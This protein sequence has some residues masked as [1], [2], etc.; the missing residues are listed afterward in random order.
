MPRPSRQSLDEDSSRDVGWLHAL[1]QVPT[2]K[3]ADGDGEPEGEQ[4]VLD[5]SAQTA[6]RRFRR[7]KPRRRKR[8]GTLTLEQVLA[9]SDAFRARHGRWPSRRAGAIAEAPGE[10]WGGVDKALRYGRRGF[11]GGSSLSRLMYQCRGVAR[12]YRR[13]LVVSEQEIVAWADAYHEQHGAWPNSGAG[14]I[15]GASVPTWA[16]VDAALRVGLHGLK[17]G[18]LLAKLLDRHR[19]KPARR[20][21]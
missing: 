16:A 10:T 9:W 6:P 18:S 5:H 20:P 19:R 7:S 14:P 3:I 12:E 1:K 11:R 2:G 21:K 4:H 8:L 17:G 13:T 15:D